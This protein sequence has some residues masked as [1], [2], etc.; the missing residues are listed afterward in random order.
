MSQ[1]IF[2]AVNNV[3]TLLGLKNQLT[4]QMNAPF[5]PMLTTT[6][7][8][9]YNIEASTAPTDL[10]ALKYFGIGINGF[11]NMTDTN[12]S[13]P[14]V[15]SAE[16]MDL[17]TPIPFR[18]LPVENDLSAGE[19][20]NYRM[21]EVRN[22][23]GNDYVLYW[24]KAIDFTGSTVE[25]NR[26]N[27]VDNTVTPY[28]FDN[29]NLNPTPIKTVGPDAIATVD[30]KVIVESN[31][32]CTVT[33]AEVAEAINILYA[34]DFR[35]A[36]ISEYGF[37]TGEDKLVNTTDYQGSPFDYTEAIYSQLSSHRCSN[38]TDVSDPAS[39]INENV[40]YQA[41]SVFNTSAP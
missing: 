27:L 28:T 22:I 33:G 19:R 16:N 10:P 24:L 9:K 41:A 37:Y 5:V 38:G 3:N 32:I 21:R 15:P 39:T 12:L 35:Y 17:H 23:D 34:G 8:S 4:A 20:A 1:G 29:S 25:V 18:V 36:R 40:S 26:V 7:N 11:Y 6:I 30:N 14:Y 13:Q 31:G 2:N